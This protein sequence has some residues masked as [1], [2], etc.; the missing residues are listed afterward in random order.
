MRI[1]DEEALKVIFDLVRHEG[2]VVGGSSGINVA[3]AIRLAEEMGPGH[4]VVTILADDGA[5]YQSKIFNPAFLKEK[6]LP[7]PEW[8]NSK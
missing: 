7:I 8:L 4:T 6:N 1:G 3:G 2:F 5:K